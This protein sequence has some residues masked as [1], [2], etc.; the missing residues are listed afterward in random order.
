MPYQWT[1]GKSKMIRAI[2]AIPAM[3]LDVLVCMGLGVA[4]IFF[5]HLVLGLNKKNLLLYGP[6]IATEVAVHQVFFFPCMSGYPKIKE[7][8]SRQNRYVV[9]AAYFSALLAA[10]FVSIFVQ[11]AIFD[12]VWYTRKDSSGTVIFTKPAYGSLIGMHQ[13]LTFVIIT[14]HTILGN[15]HLFK[16]VDPF[17]AGVCAEIITWTVWG[18]W[19]GRALSPLSNLN[20][21]G[22]YIQWIPL[23]NLMNHGIFKRANLSGFKNDLSKF[24]LLFAGVQVP[25]MICYLLSALFD[26]YVIIRPFSNGGERDPHLVGHHIW[27]L[28]A[29]AWLPF[30]ITGTRL[31]PIFYDGFCKTTD[32]KNRWVRMFVW[33]VLFLLLC[34]PFTAAFYTYFQMFIYNYLIIGVLKCTDHKGNPLS[35]DVIGWPLRPAYFFGFG[36]G[37]V[38]AVW[39]DT[40]HIS[41][42]GLKHIEDQSR[43]TENVGDCESGGLEI[44]T[45]QSQLQAFH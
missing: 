8:C 15:Y 23:V 9:F 26:Y 13:L 37:I 42:D 28:A 1:E 38:Y 33:V 39:F 29:L 20:Q 6:S 5:Y 3:L 24:G 30:Q 21:I 18:I 25:I 7:W 35:P 14:S 32:G 16:D 44:T 31:A 27:S 40:L 36:V 11:C 41:R 45:Q 22:G 43:K 19:I 12:F 34:V 4:M 10:S 2:I 17:A